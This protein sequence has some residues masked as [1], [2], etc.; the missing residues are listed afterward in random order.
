VPE[1]LY[2]KGANELKNQRKHNEICMLKHLNIL[3]N[4]HGQ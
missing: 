1:L 4:Y 3:I 2:T